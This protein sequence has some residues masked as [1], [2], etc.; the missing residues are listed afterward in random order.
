MGCQRLLPHS[1]LKRLIVDRVNLRGI[2]Y[3][4][5]HACHEFAFQNNLLI[6][7][8]LLGRDVQNKRHILKTNQYDGE[9]I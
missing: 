8:K 6:P 7:L 9:D 1:L 3:P 4:Q 2:G 5:G